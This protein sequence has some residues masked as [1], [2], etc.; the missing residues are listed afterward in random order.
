M[1]SHKTVADGDRLA[2]IQN[3]TYHMISLL[4]CDIHS[5]SVLS[6]AD[7][8]TFP[9][10]I[11]TALNIS[12]TQ[13]VADLASRCSSALWFWFLLLPAAQQVRSVRHCTLDTSTLGG[14]SIG[15]RCWREASCHFLTTDTSHRLILHVGAVVGQMFKGQRRI[16]VCLACTN[17]YTVSCRPM[18]LSKNEVAGIRALVNLFYMS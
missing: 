4:S 7:Y 10:C 6:L 13:T 15:N 3:L 17:R 2:I 5:L 18:H 11:L 16:Y 8:W 1:S 14:Q 9:H 12:A